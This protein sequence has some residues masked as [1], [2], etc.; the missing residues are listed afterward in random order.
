MRKPVIYAILLCSIIMAPLCAS[1]GV[2]QDS[3]TPPGASQQDQARAR[4]NRMLKRLPSAADPAEVT[5]HL[6]LSYVQ[7]SQ[8]A[9]AMRWLHKLAA[10]HQGYDPSGDE[11]F[12]PLSDRADYRRLVAAIHR[13]FPPVQHSRQAF[14]IPDKYL[15]PEGLAFDPTS[16]RLYMGSLY[17]RKIV[18]LF[19]N[20]STDFTKE[21]QDGLWEVLGMKVNAADNTLW[22][23]SADEDEGISGVFH[24]SLATGKLIK[25]YVMEG[26]PQ[27]HL[28]NDL[29]LNSKGDVFLTDSSAG[30]VYRISHETD[31][32]EQFSTGPE[33]PYPN[34]IAISPDDKL[35]YFAHFDGGISIIDTATRKTR[36]LQ[37]PKN[38]TV[39]G[40]DGL[41]F[42]RDSLIGIQNGIGSPRV[43]RFYLSRGN[44]RVI[45]AETLEYRSRLLSGIPTTGAIV[46]GRWFYF[47]AN[48]QLNRLKGKTIDA[49]EKLQPVRIIKLTLE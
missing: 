25:K 11:E 20:E 24:Y 2:R 48:T 1:S 10:F 19:G 31:R 3:S 23:D 9:E 34:G 45:R 21:G 17:E 36:L 7:T 32:L 43:T 49:P 12:A 22:A 6:A 41:Y 26:K 42:F 16:K 33:L 30:V 28:F 37:H 35:I 29:V 18:Q 15:I 13:E 5:Y 39:A 40:I 14:E 38:V 8:Y 4:I 27:A 46:E 47:M 44:D